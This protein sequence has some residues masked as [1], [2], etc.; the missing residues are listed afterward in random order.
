MKEPNSLDSALNSL[1]ETSKKSNTLYRVTRHE[2]VDD[3]LKNGLIPTI[4][5][6]SKSADEQDSLICLCNYESIPY[7]LIICG[8]DTV[9]K[10]DVSN[11]DTGGYT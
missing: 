5:E 3:I 8:A 11:V 2:C 10:V 4:G 9:L 7:W 1:I 6:N